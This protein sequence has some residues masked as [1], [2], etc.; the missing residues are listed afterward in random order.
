[1]QRELELVN[2]IIVCQGPVER[3]NQEVGVILNALT[4]VVSSAEGQ[5]V[6]LS[7]SS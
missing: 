7:F 1:V 4:R 2:F 6:L 3:A 5:R